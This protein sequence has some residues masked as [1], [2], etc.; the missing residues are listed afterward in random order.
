MQT[1]SVV[2][3]GFGGQGLLLAGKI[4]AHAAMAAGL[5]VSWLPSY[6]PE[7]RGGTAN[8]TVCMSPSPIGSPLVGR[9]S[10]LVVMNQPSMEKFAPRVRPGG[11]IVV[12]TSMVPKDP[13]R[14]DCVVVRVAAREVA[15]AAGAD[16]SANFVMLGAYVGAAI[17]GACAVSLERIEAAVAEE[18]EGDKAKWVPSNLTA[19]R[20]GFE[21]GR[22]AAAD[23]DALAGAQ[24]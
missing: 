12:D 16:R 1:A 3:A 20:A 4:L 15:K 14:P 21:I 23:A 7:M 17:G 18:F 11:V 24:S 5:E 2:M 19:L 8:V 13:E 6:G 22:K 10:A 9:P